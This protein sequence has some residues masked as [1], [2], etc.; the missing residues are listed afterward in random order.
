MQISVVIPAHNAARWIEPCL[1]SVAAQTRAADE[2]IV[3]VDRSSDETAEQARATGVPTQILSTD[4]GNG[5]AARNAGILAASGDWI[6]FQDADDI[7]YPTHLERAERLLSGASDVAYLSFADPFYDRAGEPI[8][9]RENPWPL[10]EPTSGLSALRF[11]ELTAIQLVYTMPAVL[12]RRDVLLE[13]G[14]LDPEQVRRHD[15]DM[16]LRV[17]AGRTWSYDPEATVKFRYDTPGSISRNYPERE[18]Y[19]L[20][21]LLKNRSAYEGPTMDRLIARAARRSMGAA[22]TDGDQ[23]H[24]EAAWQLAGPH[25]GPRDRFLFT[26]FS[27]SPRLFQ[28]FNRLRRRWRGL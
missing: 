1:A 14:M 3:I 11:L 4:F 22:F 12:A 16:W 25:L 8:L 26:L 10:R 24:R 19:W 28:A 20:R 21:A 18:Y 9:E 13:V 7:W 6:A 23:Q 27:S 5:A 17:I 15:F 2:V